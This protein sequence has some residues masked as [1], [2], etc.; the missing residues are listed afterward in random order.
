M[1]GCT[2]GYVPYSTSGQ[3]RKD[4]AQ[5]LYVNPASTI[6]FDFKSSTVQCS[7]A[8]NNRYVV[9]LNKSADGVDSIPVTED[10]GKFSCA[11]LNQNVGAEMQICK[12]PEIWDS[13]VDVCNNF[14]KNGSTCMPDGTCDCSTAVGPRVQDCWGTAKSTG[15]TTDSHWHNLIP[16]G[17]Y[18]DVMQLPRGFVKDVTYLTAYSEGAI[19]KLVAQSFAMITDS[20]DLGS[21]WNAVARMIPMEDTDI[22][23]ST[24]S[25]CHVQ[26][27]VKCQTG[28]SSLNALPYAVYSGG[29]MNW[30]MFGTICGIQGTGDS[31]QAGLDVAMNATYDHPP[32]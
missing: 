27:N 25:R 20:A 13:N 2:N 24:A 19:D 14:C 23:Y 22:L 29:K 7:D 11:V 18:C 5:V 16:T 17:K 6:P 10:Y 32:S 28:L 30:L 3:Q 8:N 9:A 15:P 31:H 26:N 4:G 1:S 21:G 12:L